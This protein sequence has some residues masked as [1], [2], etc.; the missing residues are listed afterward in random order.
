MTKRTK[1]VGV[2]GKYGTRYGA[3]L[4][5]QVKKMEITQHARY[6]CTFCGK[7]SV[8]RTAVGIWNCK[9][10]KKVVAGGAWTVSTPAAAATRSTIRR[11]REIAEVCTKTS[12]IPD[13]T[14]TTPT[15]HKFI[16]NNLWMPETCIVCLGDLSSGIGAA[17]AVPTADAK[18]PSTDGPSTAARDDSSTV[19]TDL[20]DK[21]IAQIQE[22]SFHHVDIKHA[23]GGAT[24]STL[25]VEDRTQ[26]AELDPATVFELVEDEDEDEQ[27]CQ[28]CGEDDNEDVLLICDNCD[29]MWHTYCVGLQEVP[30]SAW[31]CE[32]CQAQRIMDAHPHPSRRRARTVGRRMAT[33]HRRLGAYGDPQEDSWNQV[34]GHV[35]SSINLDLDFPY[36]DDDATAAQMRRDRQRRMRQNREAQGAFERRMEIARFA[37]A[38]NSFRQADLTAATPVIIKRRRTSQSAAPTPSESGSR[39][40][41]RRSPVRLSP[42]RVPASSDSTGPSFL[43]SLLQEVE[44]SSHASSR[45]S[46]HRPLPRTAGTP[47]DHIAPRPSSPARSPP[48]SNHSSPRALS[49]TPPPFGASR[50][51]SPV[52]L[53]S[54]IQPIYPT[55]E[56]SSRSH[57]PSPKPNGV[58]EAN[59]DRHH[60]LTTT[61][62]QKLVSS[63]LKR[64]YN[65]QTI[66]KD[67][68]TTINR[69]ISR[70]LYDRIG[71]FETIDMID[72]AK[73]EQVAHAEVEKAVGSL[74]ADGVQDLALWEDNFGIHSYALVELHAVDHGSGVQKAVGCMLYMTYGKATYDIRTNRLVCNKLYADSFVLFD[75]LVRLITIHQVSSESINSQVARMS[76]FDDSSDSD[77]DSDAQR[78]T[79]KGMLLGE[80]ANVKSTGSFATFGVLQEFVNPGISI[81][82]Q[83]A[84]IRLP[85]S[86]VDAQCLVEAS[87]RAPFG[88]GTETVIDESVRK[89]WEIDAGRV[90]FLNKDWQAYIDRMASKAAKELGVAGGAADSGS[91]RAEFYKML[92]YEP[93]AM[94]KAHK[95][96][97]K[98]EG[99]FGTLVICLPSEHTGGMVRLQH[100]NK[101]EAFDTSD[102]SAFNASYLAWY[103]DVTHE[104]E[105]VQTGYRWVLTYNLV[106]NDQDFRMSAGFLSSRVQNL[107]GILN[108][109]KQL[110]DPPQHLVFPLSHQYTDQSLRL[111]RLKGEDFSRAQHVSESSF[112][113]LLSKVKVQTGKDGKTDYL[114]LALKFCRKYLTLRAPRGGEERMDHILGSIA[115]TAMFLDDHTMFSEAVSK[116]R[117]GF[118]ESSFMELGKMFSLDDDDS[119]VFKS[120]IMEAFQK[121]GQFYR[122]LNNLMKFYKGFCGGRDIATVH[123]RQ[124]KIWLNSI[125]Y[126]AL[127]TMKEPCIEDPDALITLII[128]NA[129]SAFSQF[130]M[131]QGVRHSVD[132]FLGNIEFLT[133]LTVKLL[134]HLESSGCGGGGASDNYLT[135]VLDRL[136]QPVATGF[137]PSIYETV[138]SRLPYRHSSYPRRQSNPIKALY[139]RLQTAADEPQLGDTLLKRIQDG[140]TSKIMRWH[141]E[142]FLTRF[143]S[144][145]LPALDTS[146]SP[147][148]EFVYSLAKK[149][150]LHYVGQEPAKPTDW[151]RTGESSYTLR[152]HSSTPAQPDCAACT[153]LLEFLDDP[154]AATT[155]IPKSIPIVQ[156]MPTQQAKQAKQAPASKTKTQT[157]VAAFT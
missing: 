131:Y 21:H 103:A 153:Q 20:T 72:K 15:T 2:T 73:W 115:T 66:S 113:H 102:S 49:T 17:A 155:T 32:S 139:T 90:Q 22:A 23:V 109:W 48:S 3:S 118:A 138:I 34:W 60:T 86:P 50:P 128:D 56:S 147:V 114:S 43:Q 57:S 40:R 37:G 140:A 74:R 92:I 130:L 83:S 126:K 82:G 144:D 93:G 94:F 149:Y 44:E 145:L 18:S 136:L 4:R 47:V 91:I 51:V 52:G 133:A 99:M 100:G 33:Q 105:P 65:D 127:R 35:W 27:P 24:I 54:T 124:L 10:C 154:H 104:I 6:I 152:H 25:K 31:F 80:I 5:K 112:D 75:C 150:I 46:V 79:L 55:V 156:A 125:A 11:L 14:A 70:M 122:T 117:F 63:A 67:E 95:D 119:A 97:E 61:D 106:A 36:N 38:G 1:K 76:Y 135:L 16:A 111:S 45:T 110:E 129:D 142:T 77:S 58:A 13:A 146:S 68:Y 84:A 141:P 120:D 143:L 26:V 8:K 101:E 123:K 9:S 96:T 132:R 88:K 30:V 53:S 64:H 19:T 157:V 12:K 62:V 39:S 28:G 151:T 81:Q 134:L 69:E 85:L 29:K 116:V 71:D 121:S 108:S 41:A 98:T 78:E 148:R 87:S 89:T 59:R 137:E 7:N 42:P 107:V